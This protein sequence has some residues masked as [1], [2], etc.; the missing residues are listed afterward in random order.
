MISALIGESFFVSI[1]SKKVDIKDAA[2]KNQSASGIYL[3]ATLP[4]ATVATSILIL[5]R[6]ASLRAPKEGAESK[7]KKQKLAYILTSQNKLV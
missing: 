4:P 2:S 6:V 1:L 7:S 3:G 5:E